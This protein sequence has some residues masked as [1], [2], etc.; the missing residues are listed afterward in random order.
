VVFI[1]A[2]ITLK[3]QFYINLTC[4][5]GEGVT[6][7]LF[8]IRVTM[9]VKAPGRGKLKPPVDENSKLRLK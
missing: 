3:L 9:D 2:C 4:D 7:F 5:K 6:E 1:V 8:K